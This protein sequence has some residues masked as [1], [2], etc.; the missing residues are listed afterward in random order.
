VA[1]LAVSASVHGE[2][3]AQDRSGSPWGEAEYHVGRGDSLHVQVYE[4]PTLSGEVVVNDA[5]SISLGLIGAV[6]V[7]DLTLSE[8]ER[9]ITK[10]YAGDYLVSPS[11]AVRVIRYHSQR[12]DVL[13]EVEKPGPQYLEGQTSLIEVLSLAGGPRADNVVQVEIVGVD[14]SIRQY[15]LNRLPT[16]E[17]VLVREGD[18][19]YLR[20][21]ELVYVEGQI[22]RP[23]AVLLTPGLTVTQA[24]TLAGG[25]DET[26]NLRRVQIN[27]ADGSIVRVNVARV[28]KG[29]DEDVVLTADDHLIVPRSPF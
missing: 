27:R 1:V 17:D 12:V 19:I 22:A 14:G 24:L 11:V 16:E 21:G 4:E 8:V 28:H 7:C 6:A 23:G 15:D 29:Y 18:R 2:A 26:A 20:P 13:G 10:R 5:C 25:P 9:E 3:L